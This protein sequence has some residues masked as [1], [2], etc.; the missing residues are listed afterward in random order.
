MDDVLLR[1]RQRPPAERARARQRV[2]SDAPE[3]L[4]F[5]ADDAAIASASIRAEMRGQRAAEV[6]RERE[7]RGFRRVAKVHARRGAVARERRRVSRVVRLRRDDHVRHG[8]RLVSAVHEQR[9]AV[10]HLGF[11][12]EH[13]YLE[14]G[15]GAARARRGGPAAAADGDE[16]PPELSRV[17]PPRLSRRDVAALGQDRVR[18]GSKRARERGGDGGEVEEASTTTTTT[19]SGSTSASPSASCV[20]SPRR[21]RGTSRGSARTPSDASR[22]NRS[23]PP[24]DDA[25]TRRER[26]CRRAARRRRRRRR[27]IPTVAPPG[28][29]ARRRRR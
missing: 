23:R 12:D 10:V 14:H 26:R 20:P 21:P 24:R 13:G 15:G 1:P 6:L 9:R 27:R 3:P 22:R 17:D 4:L 19:T 29:A 8:H 7:H 25:R 5:D 18:A 11:D 28:R 2:R 16:L